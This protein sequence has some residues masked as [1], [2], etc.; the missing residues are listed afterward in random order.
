MVHR[1]TRPGSPISASLHSRKLLMRSGRRH[2]P[3]WNV[4]SGRNGSKI[5][6]ENK[7]IAFL[8][9]VGSASLLSTLGTR[10]TDQ[11]WRLHWPHAIRDKSCATSCY[12]R[13]VPDRLASHRR[14]VSA[15][16]SCR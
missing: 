14:C 12:E 16:I 11:T 4:G 10:T 7:L 8:R 1:L 9:D 15:E 13:L 6:I 2:S 3:I 5:A